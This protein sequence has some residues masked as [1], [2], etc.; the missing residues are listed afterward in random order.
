MNITLSKDLSHSY[1][2]VSTKF[3]NL[4]R[5][6]LRY[7]TLARLLLDLV[8]IMRNYKECSCINAK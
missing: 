4:S 7:T 1:P 2:A 3:L 8:K 5:L 6:P